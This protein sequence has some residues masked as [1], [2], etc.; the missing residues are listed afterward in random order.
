MVGSLTW[1]D[2]S[3]RV[4]SALLC[5][6]IPWQIAWADMV[7]AT[8]LDS[9]DIVIPVFNTSLGTLNSVSL[10]VTLRSGASANGG[11]HDHSNY[12]LVS[13]NAINTGAFGGFAPFS[14]P[15]DPVGSTTHFAPTPLY[16][17]GGLTI[18][19]FNLSLLSAGFHGHTATVSFIRAQQV[20]P[21]AFRAIASIDTAVDSGHA[22]SYFP[23]STGQTLSGSNVAPF[24]GPTNIVIPAGAFTTFMDSSHN[25]FLTSFGQ[26]VGSALG[27][28]TFF[29]PA[30][31]GPSVG[32]HVHTIDPRFDV[33]ATFDYTAV[34]EASQIFAGSLIAATWA[35]WVQ[36]RRAIGKRCSE[37]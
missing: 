25:H 7:T 1:N 34:P 30:S 21:T 14:L 23:T 16:S 10:T 26:T 19:Q 22:H 35:V 12:T 32:S 17:G 27:P 4:I 20:G 15:A 33:I 18:G 6:V 5:G 31:S 13:S 37:I 29:F 2:I 8:I 24:L 11:G 9:D 3:V 36:I 28:F